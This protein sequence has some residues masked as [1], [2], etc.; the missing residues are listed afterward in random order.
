MSYLTCLNRELPPRDLAA[1]ISNRLSRIVIAL[2]TF[3]SELSEPAFSAPGVGVVARYD[4]GDYAP[5][6]VFS[7]ASPKFRG[8]GEDRLPLEFSGRKT[9]IV[10]E[11]TKKKASAQTHTE[12][13]TRDRSNDW[14]TY[15]LWVDAT[16]YG[17]I[18]ELVTS[19]EAKGP[20]ELVRRALR[21]REAYHPED[22]GFEGAVTLLKANQDERLNITLPPQSRERVER[23][24]ASTGKS[25]RTLVYEAI[26]IFAELHERSEDANEDASV[27]DQICLY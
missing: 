20:S 18:Q 3:S 10:K 27:G 7:V 25:F 17:H 1:F 14:K 5:L 11:L 2:R 24:K 19:I 21:A 13:T 16:T 4:W 12:K 22:S 6:A 8:A 9:G 15:Q 23:L 26:L